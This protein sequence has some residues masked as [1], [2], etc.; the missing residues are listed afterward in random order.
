VKRIEQSFNVGDIIK[1]NNGVLTMFVD[2][3]LVLFDNP[4]RFRVKDGAKSV[5]KLQANDIALIVQCIYTP[6]SDPLSGEELMMPRYKLLTSKTFV[7][8]IDVSDDLEKLISRAY[9]EE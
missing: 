6:E 7:G 3:S 4:Y 8:W 5:G 9:S 1:L 2:M